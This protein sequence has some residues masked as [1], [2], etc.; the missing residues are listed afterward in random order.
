MFPIGDDDKSRM[1][2]PLVTYV[3]IALKVVLFIALRISPR[4]A[5]PVQLS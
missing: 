2:F 3:L 5:S 1:T 4:M